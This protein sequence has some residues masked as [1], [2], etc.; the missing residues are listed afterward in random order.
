M[1]APFARR[2]PALLV[3][4]ATISLA[5]A[6]AL[7]GFATSLATA[8]PASPTVCGG[9]PPT[10]VG[11]GN[12]DLLIG[13]AARDVIIG[14]GGNDVI[15]GRGG[16]DVICG[17]KGDDDLRGNRDNDQLFGDDGVDSCNGGRGSRDKAPGCEFPRKIP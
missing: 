10:I 17:S 12:D 14:H 1:H 6:A 11:T 2:S 7:L 9:V 4:L 5:A 13:T 3:I 16:K 8:A 15:L